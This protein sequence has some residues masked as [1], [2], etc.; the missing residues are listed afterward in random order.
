[1]TPRLRKP[2]TPLLLIK[3]IVVVA[4][5]TNKDRPAKS[6]VSSEK[7]V[8]NCAKAKKINPLIPQLLK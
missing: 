5:L 1:M 8:I 6:W 3:I 7:R 2:L 4:S